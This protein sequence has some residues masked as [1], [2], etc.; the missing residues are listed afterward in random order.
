MKRLAV[1][2][3][4][5]ALPW[6]AMAQSTAVLVAK[7]DAKKA[8][9]DFAGA[10]ADYSQVI[11]IDP[12]NVGAYLGRATIRSLQGDPSGAIADDTKAIALDPSN[13][14]AYSN[15]GNARA[16]KGDLPGAIADFNKA[17]ELDPRHVRAFLNR[18]NIKNLQKKY[19]AAIA[20]YDQAIAL[21]PKNALAYYNR[22][23]AKRALGDYSGAQSD[24]SKAIDFDSRD[25]QAYLNRA[26]LRMAQKNWNGALDDLNKGVSLIPQARQ[27]YPRIYLWITG[28]KR[29][30]TD[31]A[32]RDLNQ[33]LEQSPKTYSDTWG[34]QIARFV[35]GQAYES[36]FLAAAQAQQAKKNRNQ[37]AQADYYVGLKRAMA[38]DTA[39]ATRYFNEC[40]KNG[41]P[42]LHEYILAREELKSSPGVHP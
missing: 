28:V 23:G 18:G 21:D 34:W 41:T 36:H 17:I 5:L 14:V 24:Y 22:A 8:K 3:L 12:K 26:V 25:V 37:V 13:V 2:A 30:K 9:G 11:S 42:S 19:S 31:Q 35:E 39:G 10:L 27:A 29:G 7:A 33:Y 40:V 38:G 20:D 32:N 1:V 16:F 6:V 4:S 15:R